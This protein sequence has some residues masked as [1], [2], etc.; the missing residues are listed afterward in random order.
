MLIGVSFLF[1]WFERKKKLEEV[2]G[3][4]GLRGLLSWNGARD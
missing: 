4:G 2:E 1:F 3:G